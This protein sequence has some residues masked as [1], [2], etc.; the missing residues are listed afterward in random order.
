MTRLAETNPRSNEECATQPSPRLDYLSAVPCTAVPV[1]AHACTGLRASYCT[2]Y[3][4]P[5]CSRPTPC[6][7]RSV[8]ASA[9]DARCALAA[10]ASGSAQ[11]AFRSAAHRRR[12]AQPDHADHEERRSTSLLCHKLLARVREPRVPSRLACDPTQAR[13]AARLAVD[14]ERLVEDAIHAPRPAARVDRQQ[15]QLDA[16]EL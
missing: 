14:H 6:D 5:T 11:L 15:R 1:Y 3:R 12:L 13:D 4:R 16:Q 10:R 7:E 8:P 2:S 9:L